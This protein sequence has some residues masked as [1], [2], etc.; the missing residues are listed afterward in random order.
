MSGSIDRKNPARSPEQGSTLPKSGLATRQRFSLA[1]E[2]GHWH[3]HRGKYLFCGPEQIGNPARG[4]LDPERQA[5]E[6]ASDLIFPDFMFRPA[7]GKLGRV[8]LSDVREIAE[9]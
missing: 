7:I 4:P 8:L 2:L 5:D 3:H 6:F 9:R 1:H